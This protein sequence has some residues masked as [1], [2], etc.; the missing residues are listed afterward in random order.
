MTASG[1]ADRSG[2]SAR[3]RVWGAGRAHVGQ[4]HCQQLHDDGAAL[5]GEMLDV[6]SSADV[7]THGS[8]LLVLVLLRYR[9]AACADQGTAHT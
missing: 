4:R 1:A 6:A 8:A 9:R 5:P 7:A 3:E 2:P